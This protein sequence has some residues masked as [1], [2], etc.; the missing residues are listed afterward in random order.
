MSN[1][2]YH[3]TVVTVA[4]KFITSFAKLYLT[5]IIKINIF[6]QTKSAISTAIN[7]INLILL[8]TCCMRLSAGSCQF[9]VGRARSTQPDFLNRTLHVNPVHT[10]Y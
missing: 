6:L 3:K 7:P 2:I 5:F 9:H 8:T 4:C 10:Q 1:A